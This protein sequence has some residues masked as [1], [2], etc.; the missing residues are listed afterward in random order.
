MSGLKQSNSIIA[1][2]V[3]ISGNLTV[4][5]TTTTIE[6]TTLTVDDKNI[7]IASVDSPSDSTADGAGITIKGASDKT[8]LWENDDDSF[9]TNQHWS[10]A[11]NGSQNLGTTAIGWGDAYIADDKKI[12]FGDGQDASIEYDEDGTDQLRIA[13][14]AAGVVISGTNPKLVIGDGGTEDTMIVFDGVD[15][16]YRIGL[17]DGTDKLEIGAGGAH[18]T[19]IGLA[20]NSSGHITQLGHQTS[21]TSGHFLKFDGSKV[22]FDSV[23]SGGGADVGTANTFTEAQTIAKDTDAELVSLILKNASNAADTTGVVSMRFDLADTGDNVV[24]SG[25]IAVKKEA[26]F[27]ST[28]ATQDSSM[29]F[30]TSLN[31]TLTEWA[32]PL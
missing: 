12:Y 29:V 1:N 24:D 27:T 31:G 3:T 25:K 6:S 30:S 14:P 2:D 5:G 28:A 16:D 7:E 20:M 4:T 32:T 17:D 11:A 23:S 9:H 21:P 19:T 26:S 22:V 15:V 18:G 13:Q 10:A 8:I